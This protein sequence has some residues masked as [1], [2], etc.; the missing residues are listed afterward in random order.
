MSIFKNSVN[1]ILTGVFYGLGFCLV[2]FLFSIASSFY[3]QQTFSTERS[4]EYSY[5][6]D[7]DEDKCRSLSECDEPGLNFEIVS[8]K[9]DTES[10]IL[11]GKIKNDGDI[12]WTSVSL[13]VELFDQDGNFI[14]ECSEYISGGVAPNI[15]ENFKISCGSN[16]SKANLDDYHHYKIKIA[17]AHAF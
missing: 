14:D 4:T 13:K 3:F 8:E 2:L 9:I 15:T 17:D 12:K 5:V 1:K 16:C 10:L 7:Y 11:L 6:S